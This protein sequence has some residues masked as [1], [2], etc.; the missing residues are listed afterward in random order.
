[1]YVII[2]LSFSKH[3][4]HNKIVSFLAHIISNAIIFL[5]KKC[6]SELLQYKS[7]FLACLY[8]V[9]EE[10]LYY[11]GV[12]VSIGGGVIGGGVSKK[13]NVKVFYVIGKALSGELSCPCDR[14]CCTV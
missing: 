12:D 10:L 4:K 1:M 5:T 8:E 13:F 11:A 2:W 6:K 3:Q 7:S 9:Q 14:S